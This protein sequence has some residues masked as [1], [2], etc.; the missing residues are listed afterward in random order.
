MKSRLMGSTSAGTGCSS[1]ASRCSLR[2]A[3]TLLDASVGLAQRVEVHLGLFLHTLHAIDGHRYL[4]VP[5]EDG[6]DVGVPPR[7]ATEL[8]EVAADLLVDLLHA[9]EQR[10]A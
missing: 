3:L 10:I 2:R 4:A 5:V 6:V 9:L 8:E 7:R 1:A